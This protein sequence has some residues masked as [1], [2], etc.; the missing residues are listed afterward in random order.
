MNAWSNGDIRQG[1]EDDEYLRT[2][3]EAAALE[4]E[5]TMLQYQKEQELLDTEAERMA[6]AERQAA[7][8]RDEMISEL[9][10]RYKEADND[11]A[12]Y[13]SDMDYARNQEEYDFW[14]SRADEAYNRRDKIDSDLNGL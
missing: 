1:H 13:K 14:K 4:N 9:R 10:D 6:E 8:E 5:T 3:S 11:Y 2:T 12:Q 7:T